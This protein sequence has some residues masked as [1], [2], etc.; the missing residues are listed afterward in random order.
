MGENNWA[1]NLIGKFC[2][3][4]RSPFHEKKK[5]PELPHDRN[6]EC[7]VF[8]WK[9]QKGGEHVLDACVL[10]IW[11]KAKSDS[12]LEEQHHPNVSLRGWNW[13][14]IPWCRE[15]IC[16]RSVLSVRYWDGWR[17]LTFSPNVWEKWR[18]ALEELQR[19][20]EGT[21]RMHVQF[22]GIIFAENKK[23]KLKI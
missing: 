2:Y 15:N 21:E 22:S 8:C 14:K 12:H 13:N 5:E 11:H 7:G 16:Y 19:G 3:A 20:G 4:K 6:D 17:L 10:Q 1:T 18:G 23:A 9:K